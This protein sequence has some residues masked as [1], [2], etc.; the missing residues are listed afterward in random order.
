MEQGHQHGPSVAEAR[1]LMELLNVLSLFSRRTIIEWLPEHV[2]ERGLTSERFMVMFEL[3]LQPDSSLKQLASSM[4]VSPSSM[5]VMVNSMVEAGH[6]A[7]V[8]DAEDRRRVVLRLTQSGEVEL[9][10]AESYLVERYREYLD[11]LPDDD[12]KALTAIST[13]MLAVVGKIMDRS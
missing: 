10:A 13:E 6:V 12:R 2:A 8:T 9:A 7:R 5:S 3:M 11:A 4:G 1:T